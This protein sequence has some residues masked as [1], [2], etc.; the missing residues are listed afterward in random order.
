M[1]GTRQILQRF[2][3]TENISKVTGTMETVSAV[4]YRKLF[5]TWRESIDFYDALAQLAYLVVTAEKSIDHPLMH[6]NEAKTNAIIVTGSNRGLCGGY[7]SNVYKQVEVHAN[8]AR[9]FGRNLEIY[10]QG[11]KVITHL[12][13]RKI[14]LSGTFE[15]FEE[16]PSS[17]QTNEIADDFIDRFLQG[18]IGRLGFVYTRFF[19]PANQR[20]QTLTILPVADLIDDLTTR[21][22]VIWPWEL[23]FEDFLLSP[24]P[25]RIFDTLARMMIRTAIKGC[26]LEAALSEHLGRVVAMR[27]ATDNANEMISE[28][29]QEYNRARQSQITMELLDIIG[30][31]AT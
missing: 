28:L 19:S 7:N 4:K 17:Q 30:A 31:T 10:A 12:S 3:A 15:E 20:V 11:K 6:P 18:K 16:V 14:E 27:S 29:T 25:E 26:F 5:N 13:N 22:T 1:A 2:K 21:A 9:R 8:M 24:S 23:A